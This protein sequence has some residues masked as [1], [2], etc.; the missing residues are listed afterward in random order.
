GAGP[1]TAF[2]KIVLP[3]LSPTLF[4]LTVI[5]IINAFQ[6]FGQIHLLTKGGP[7]GSTEV[8]VYSIYKEAF[9]NY[10]YGTG[11]ALAL[12]LFA[13]VLI[14][15]IIQFAFVEKKVHYQ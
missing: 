11:S 10:Q 13:I 8:L 2:I 7:A 3:L 14:L 6:S 15:T 1:F 5:S 12:V 9:V 4:F